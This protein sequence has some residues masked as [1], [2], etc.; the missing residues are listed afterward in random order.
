M[1]VVELVAVL[2]I[3]V[4]TLPNKPEVEVSVESEYLLA[5]LVKFVPQ[6]VMILV[7]VVP[8]PVPS[9]LPG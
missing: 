6:A 4:R 3:A 9:W 8:D 5:E 1:A 7:A 2:S